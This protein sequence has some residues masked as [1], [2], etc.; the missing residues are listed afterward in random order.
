MTFEGRPKGSEGGN[1]VKNSVGSLLCKGISWCKKKTDAPL[2]HAMAAFCEH[3][4]VLLCHRGFQSVVLNT[5]DSN[6][7][8]LCFV[9]IS[10]TEETAGTQRG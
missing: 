8:I 7:D 9:Y 5:H 1:Y 3:I 10:N 4:Y 6:K 2:P